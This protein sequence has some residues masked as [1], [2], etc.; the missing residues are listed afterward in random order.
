MTPSGVTAWRGFFMPSFPTCG[1][2]LLLFYPP[3]PTLP[4]LY[5]SIIQSLLSPMSQNDT[6]LPQEFLSEE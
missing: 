6:S 1:I 5:L 3:I 2:S 4:I